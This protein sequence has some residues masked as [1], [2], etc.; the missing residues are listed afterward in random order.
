MIEIERV[1]EVLNYIAELKAVVFDLDDTLYGE[2]DYVRSGCH[3]VAG[4]LLQ[5]EDC[6]EKLWT[7]FE[8]GKSAFDE[9][10]KNEGIYTDELKQKCLQTY[11]FQKPDIHLYDGVANMLVKMRATGYKLGII[12]DGRL[13]GQRAKIEALGL[14]EYV[15]H[16][17]I[18][19]ELGGVE[20][21]KPNDTAFRMMKEKL[22]VKF[23]EMCYVGDNIK[24]DFVAP[25][26][27]G[28]QCIWFRNKDGLYYGKR[29]GN[30][31][32]HLN[33]S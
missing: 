30:S 16:I 13:E 6:E 29:G 2:K 23:S 22:D 20:F 15:D 33:I 25:E 19:D 1:S 11:R 9:V 28:M 8:K 21:R 27:L 3:A 14:E 26:K 7:A 5:V 4:I 17:I 31:S 12:T 24:K 32:A 18:T 10:L